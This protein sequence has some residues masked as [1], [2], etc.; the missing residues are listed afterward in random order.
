MVKDWFNAG[1]I[2]NVG[3]SDTEEQTSVLHCQRHNLKWKCGTGSSVAAHYRN[4][5]MVR[6]EKGND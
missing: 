3:P 6:T 5:E 2:F 4:G 1:C